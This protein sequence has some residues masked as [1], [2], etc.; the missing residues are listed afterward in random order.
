MFQVKRNELAAKT[1]LTVF[2]TI[3]DDEK[4]NKR[5]VKAID[6]QGD[7]QNYA[8]N[9]KAQMTDWRMMEQPGFKELAETIKTVT[10]YA[11]E[12]RYNIKINPV[13]TDMWGVKYKSE[14]VAIPHDHYPSTWSCVYYINPPKNAPGLYFPEADTEIK[15]ENGLLIL[16]EGNVKHEVRPAKYKGYRYVVSANL[17]HFCM[18]VQKK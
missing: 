10:V 18:V 13:I 12:Q 11:S 2:E 1:A 8:S 6:K 3:I 4:M 15:L 5:L 9:V 7:K 17:Y 16:F 14:E